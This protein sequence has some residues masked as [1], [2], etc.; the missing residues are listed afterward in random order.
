MSILVLDEPTAVLTESAAEILLAAVKKL[1]QT[2]IAVIF[3]SHRLHEIVNICDRVLTLR[4]GKSVRDIPA[5]Q[6]TIED[7]AVSMV[8]REVNTAARR[9]AGRS[10][11]EPI[12]SVDRLWVDMPGEIVRNASFEVRQG[13]IF[14][15]GGLAGQGKI[16][17]PNG[18]MSLYPAGG[19]VQLYIDSMQPVGEGLLYQEFLR[20]RA[21]LE[22]EGL[23][24]P[25]HCLLYTSPSPRDS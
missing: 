25:S 22:A 5:S 21:Q 13:E 18:I 3:I 15:I 23:F 14:G 24:D 7:I 9:E 6:T 20:L 19:Q 8:G 12:L 10:F 2:G 1:A 11:G 4:D 16:C 17:I